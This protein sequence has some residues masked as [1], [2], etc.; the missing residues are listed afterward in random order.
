MTAIK[1]IR[2]LRG[3]TQSELA[4]KVN[5]STVTLSRYENGGRDPRGAD[6]SKMAE[7]LSCTV[8]ELLG[9]SNPTVPLQAQ[10]E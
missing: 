1:E 7:V 5:L 2:E 4:E 8:D 10:G 6:L 3:M 9:I